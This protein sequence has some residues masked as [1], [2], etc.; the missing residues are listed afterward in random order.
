M[1][2]SPSCRK[3]NSLQKRYTA[4]CIGPILFSENKIIWSI[5]GRKL[6]VKFYL[7]P[8]V[9]NRKFYLVP[10]VRNGKIY[11][12][13][14]DSYEKK[15]FGSQR[16]NK[17]FA[18]NLNRYLTS[19]CILQQLIK[20]FPGPNLFNIHENLIEALLELQAYADVQAV[21]AKYDGTIMILLFVDLVNLNCFTAWFLGKSARFAYSYG[22]VCFCVGV[23]VCHVPVTFVCTGHTFSENQKCTKW[24]L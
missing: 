20:D 16:I 9:R 17:P 3:F 15:L 6:M 13:P 22:L 10:R 21:L 1:L 5:V 14:N 19:W 24:H 7:V 11:S 23:S 4:L 2:F 8:G 18:T 12:V